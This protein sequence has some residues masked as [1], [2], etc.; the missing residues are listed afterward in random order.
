MIALN[1]PTP[2][3]RTQN[4]LTESWT[5]APQIHLEV[6]GEDPTRQLSELAWVGLPRRASFVF[7]AFDVDLVHHLDS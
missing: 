7:V 1:V 4:Y 5:Q 6:A 3:L 2:Y